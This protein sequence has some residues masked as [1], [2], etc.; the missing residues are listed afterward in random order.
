MPP[1][2][3]W[4]TAAGSRPKA[5]LAADI[6]PRPKAGVYCF[7]YTVHAPDFIPPTIFQ[8]PLACDK[9]RVYTR[10]NAKRSLPLHSVAQSIPQGL[11]L[12]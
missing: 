6:E 9:L 3:W 7:Y 1:V 12:L 11:V 4:Q 5:S 10:D 8:T 2:F